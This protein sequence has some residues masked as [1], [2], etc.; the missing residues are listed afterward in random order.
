MVERRPLGDTGL[1][2]APLVLGGNVFGV[3]G[4]DAARSFAV[5]DAFVDGG[6]TMIDSA[7]MYSNYLPDGKGGDSEAMIGAWLAHRGRRDD[8]QIATKVGGPMG[9]GLGGLGKAYLPRA[10][11][12]SLRRLR[13]DYVDLYFAHFDDESVPQEEVAEAFDTLVRAGKVRSIGASNFTPARL[14]SALDI[15]AASGLTPYTVFQP[16]YNL[17]ERDL[18]RELLPLCMARGVGVVTFFSLAQGYLTGKYR[19]PDDLSQSRRGGGVQKYMEGKGP[20][21]LAVMDRIAG[22]HGVSHAAVALAWVMAKPGVAAPIASATT[23]GQLH[24]LMPSL[25]LHLS[26]EEMARLDAAGI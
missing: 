9:P 22:D 20:G 1:S 3:N 16:Q 14:G 6:G 11:E 8:V 7:D 21:M 23:V 15:A 12:A 17:L 26:Q 25:T 10:V 24:D 5:L 19:S 2:I 18:E 4:M 13:T